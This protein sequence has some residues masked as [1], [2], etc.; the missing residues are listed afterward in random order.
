MGKFETL[1]SQEKII[2]LDGAMGT[3]LIASGLKSGASPD[4]MNV[5][6]PEVV[7]SVHQAYI[8]AGSRIILTNSFGGTHFR[9]KRHGH[10]G[11]VKE[12]N[13]AAA[14]NA[15]AAA[16]ASSK[17]VVVAGALGP[18]GEMM[19]PMG[20]LTFEDAKEAFT[21]QAQG[22]AE[23]G[24][25]AFWV[26]TMS[27]LEEVR[28][29]VE[30]IKSVSNLPV[31]TT[32]TF[33]TKGRTMM[34]VAPVKAVEKLKTTGVSA[35]GANC[36]NGPEEI[37]MVIEQ[38]KTTDPEVLLVAKANAGLPKIVNGEITYDGTP[39]VLAEYAV[40][41]RGLG[42]KFIGACC[43]STPDHIRAMAEALGL[44][45]GDGG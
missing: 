7:R 11:Q 3:M 5:S 13:K 27:D 1:L 28:A 12:F 10:E 31:V 18:T 2:L 41:A 9:L 15:R 30:G 43:G 6:Q 32:M 23:G 39:Q 16:D 21:E 25:D 45:F 8:Q 42:A 33:D 40:K 22:L 34:G 36:G 20:K 29:A 44:P 4:E 35:L 26:E 24:V 38:M 14:E 19:K 37:Q 17:L